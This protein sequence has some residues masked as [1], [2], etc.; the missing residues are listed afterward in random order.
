MFLEFRLKPLKQRK[1]VCGTAGKAGQ[2]LVAIQAPHL[3]CIALQDGIPERYLSVPANNG[4][5]TAANA[6]DCCA[7]KLLHC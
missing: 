7:I 4:G 1:R 5:T 2:Y 6:Q 3:A